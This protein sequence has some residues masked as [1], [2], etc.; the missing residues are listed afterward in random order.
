MPNRPQ[1]HFPEPDT[2]H[3]WEGVK[4]GEIRYQTCD[5]CSGRV[6][7]YP[8]RHCQGCGGNNLRWHVSR[9]E[10]AVYTFSVIRQNR[11]PGFA[12]MGAYVLAFVDLDEG[13]RLL[14]NVVGVANPLTGVHVGQRV[15][16]E[17]EQQDSGEYPIP[18]FRPV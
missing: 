10:G 3:Y 4:A 7:F 5:D 13:P 2:Q 11:L 6:N 16:V 8:T 12:E 1:P 15:K 14:T 18:V 9:G 17:F